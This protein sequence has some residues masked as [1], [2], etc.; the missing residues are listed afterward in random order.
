MN[1]KP[2]FDAFR[3]IL[4]RGFRQSEVDYIDAALNETADKLAG[5]VANPSAFFAYTRR[6]TGR[7]NQT[8]VDSINAILERMKGEPRQHI[9]YVL[10]TAWHEARFKPIREIGRGRG[11]PYGK[12]GKYGQA[13]YGRGL[14]QLTWDFNYEWA[15]RRLGLDGALLRNFDLAL[16]PKIAADVL[17][18]GMQ[19]GAFARDG[20][21]L[22]AYGPD[23]S[24]RFDYVNARRTVNLLDRA[25]RIAGYARHFEKALE[26]AA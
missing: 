23:S 4:G 8:Q 13:Q 15:D 9:A 22:S 14:V 26:M 7:L 20:K 16:E 2:I 19:E 25:E 5:E 10:A 6:L 12:K 21:G 17:V 3:K 24:G 1:R 18:Y 11:K